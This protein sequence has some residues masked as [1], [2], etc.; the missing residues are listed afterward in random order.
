MRVA[1]VGFGDGRP[2]PEEAH[3]RDSIEYGVMYGDSDAD[4]PVGE[5][6]DLESGYGEFDGV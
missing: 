1:V 2:S 5:K 3:Q 4:T 6:R